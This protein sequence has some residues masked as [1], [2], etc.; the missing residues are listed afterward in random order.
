MHEF[1]CHRIEILCDH[2]TNEYTF[3]RAHV[4]LDMDTDE[5]KAKN[6][7]QTKTKLK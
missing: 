6:Y 4:R 1:S 3:T 2:I 5:M 7:E